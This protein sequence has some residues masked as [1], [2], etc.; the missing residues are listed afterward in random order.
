MGLKQALRKYKDLIINEDTSAQVRAAQEMK[1]A[2]LIILR[3]QGVHERSYEYTFVKKSHL[4][5]QFPIGYLVNSLYAHLPKHQAI[6]IIEAYK[7]MT[8]VD[9]LST[10]MITAEQINISNNL[11]SLR[12]GYNEEPLVPAD[13]YEELVKYAMTHTEDWHLIE[14]L[15]LDRGVRTLPELLSTLTVVKEAGYAALGQGAL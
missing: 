10:P 12:R 9:H 3:E 4:V 7:N 5:D 13:Q 2:V 15:I 11:M 6:E 1:K 14:P 8:P